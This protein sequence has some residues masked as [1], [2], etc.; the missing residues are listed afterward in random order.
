MSQSHDM[1]SFRSLESG[2]VE[3]RERND[4]IFSRS[5]ARVENKVKHTYR[6]MESTCPFL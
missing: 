2:K 4:I 1:T 6:S 3:T 5:A